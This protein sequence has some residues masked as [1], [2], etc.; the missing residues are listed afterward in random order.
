[1]FS[2]QQPYSLV[3]T[4]RPLPA[5]AARPPL[6]LL[7]H[8]VGNNEHTPLPLVAGLES[9]F[10]VV[11]AR[12]PYM[13]EPGSYTWFEVCTLPSGTL[14]H[15]QQAEA[16]RKLVIALIGELIAGYG[17]DPRQVFLLGFSQGAI[18]AASVALTRP[19]LIAGAVLASGSILP[20]L[21][22]LLAPAA[23][24]ASLPLLVI[25]GVDDRVVPIHYARATRDLLGTLP[26][27]L[28]YKEYRVGHEVCPESIRDIHGWLAAQL[29]PQSSPAG[30]AGAA[31]HDVPAYSSARN[32]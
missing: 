6:L 10:L 28:T 15:M 3:Y 13:F 16:S 27:Q 4:G 26:V 2:A 31:Q 32:D 8:G 22:P 24:L 18:L 21:R 5:H 29:D 12:A 9:Q 1:M 23:Q 25:H 14:V 19:D 20:E 7:L 30:S 11:S 17:V